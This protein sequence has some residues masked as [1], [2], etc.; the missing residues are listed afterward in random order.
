LIHFSNDSLNSSKEGH[1]L[2]GKNLLHT[3]LYPSYINV[4]SNHVENIVEYDDI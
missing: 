1:M 3:E 4:K 2:S